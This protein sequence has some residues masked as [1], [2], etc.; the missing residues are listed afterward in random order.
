[1]A[2]KLLKRMLVFLIDENV[3]NMM[4]IVPRFIVLQSVEFQCII[5]FLASTRSI[6]L[7]FTDFGKISE[8]R[9]RFGARL[10]RIFYQ[11]NCVWGQKSVFWSIINMICDVRSIVRA[12][13]RAQSNNCFRMKYFWNCYCSY[14]LFSFYIADMQN[15]SQLSWRLI[16]GGKSRCTVA[17]L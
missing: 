16:I 10:V 14:V 9:G 13:V 12:E 15:A 11:V 2:F 5:S 4:L 17:I 7:L 6:V 8:I 3:V 1:M